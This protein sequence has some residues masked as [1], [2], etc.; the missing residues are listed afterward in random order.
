MTDTL[1]QA[2][3]EW[4]E[5]GVAVFPCA[6][7]KRP[8][9][10]DGFYSA[11]KDP[12]KIRLMFSAGGAEMIGGRMGKESGLF[13]IDFDLY[14]AGAQDYFDYL[15]N[16][17]LFTQTQMHTTKN[18]GIHAIY[19]SKTGYPNC[20]PHNGVEVKGEGGY[21][22]LPPSTGYT[23][24][25]EGI[26]TA[27]P[28]LVQELMASQR[29]SS[30]STIDQLKKQV[31]SAAAF[32]EPLAQ[33]AARRSAQGHTPERI[34]RELLDL[35]NGSVASQPNHARHD[36]WAALANDEGEELSRI[37]GSG[38]DKYNS[39]AKTEKVREVV[40]SSMLEGLLASGAGLFNRDT[41]D[42]QA[43][44][45]ASQKAL[46]QSG[47]LEWPFADDGYN[48][49]DERSIFDQEFVA[50]P[51]F[52]ERESVLI[53]A[54][55][56]A[57]KTAIALKLSMQVAYGEDMGNDFKVSK[58]RPVLYFTLEGARA[59]EMRIRAEHDDRKNRGVAVPDRDMLFVVDRPHN[60]GAPELR[61]ANCAKIVLHNEMCK[62]EFGTELGLVVIDTL[63]KAM[64]GKDQNSV[65]DTSELFEMI[66]FLRSHGVKA[67]IVFIHHLSKQ[68]NVR[69]S[70]N[71]EAE[72]DLVL[73]VKK[74][75]KAGLVYLDIRRARSIDE[76]VSYAFKFESHYLGET[77]QGHKLHAP[78]VR[79]VGGEAI[80]AVGKTA[81]A[82]MQYSKAM[83][84]LIKLGAGRHPVA[85]VVYALGTVVKIPIPTG[86]RP[87]FATKQVTAAI[88][89]A[90]ANQLSWAYGDYLLRLEKEGGFIT[91]LSI[92]KAQ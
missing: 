24:E 35:L 62:Q 80:A 43:D 67:T 51:L 74:D 49:F 26:T 60:F 83:D 54:E 27:T 11:S 63:T 57:G 79:L 44:F 5:K 77:K 10:E 22:I 46:P 82:A 32:H 42:E 66:G 15:I 86:R 65:D 38:N 2:A 23:V 36:R 47:T 8:I 14:K 1:T 16:K 4:A 56:K 64:P 45:T 39:S 40:N 69:G 70:T 50:Y 59:V 41:L 89:N 25:H 58:K 30:T 55:P 68:G 75:D 18:G 90:C 71:I 48:S 29:Q 92:L 81:A 37:V 84:E 12:D 88:E 21:I 31:L 19:H 73:G 20:V 61:D 9:T 76:E 91:A 87:N 52:A 13:A 17:D 33:I 53:A 78:I 85:E 72:V 28:A 34:Q 7:N 3:I 6:S